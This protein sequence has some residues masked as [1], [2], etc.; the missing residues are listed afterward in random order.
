LADEQE[1][2]MLSGN[3]IN[4]IMIILKNEFERRK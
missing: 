2:N 1:K 3:S 4:R